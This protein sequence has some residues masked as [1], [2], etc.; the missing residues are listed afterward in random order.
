VHG[1]LAPDKREETLIRGLL[2][3]SRRSA[4]FPGH[5]LDNPKTVVVPARAS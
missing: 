5:R 1:T 4:G 3:A 2:A